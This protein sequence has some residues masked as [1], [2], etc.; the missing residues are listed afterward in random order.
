MAHRVAVYIDGF[1]LYYGMTSKGWSRYLWL[2]LHRLAENLLRPEQELSVVRYFTAPLLA[3]PND[4][5]RVKRQTTYLDALSSR[6]SL[7]I[8]L[9]Y[10]ISKTQNCRNCGAAR[11]VYEEK[12]T[13]VNIAVAML[14]DAYDDI[15]DT[16]VL[17]SAD[18]DLVRPV[19]TVL[20]RF[21]RKRVV[22]AFPPGRYSN[23]LRDKATASFIIG[24]GVVANSQLPD[25]M[26]SQDGHSLS[27][28]SNWT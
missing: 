9:G 13:D 7:S 14:A 23:D 1:N 17:V 4:S 10:Y 3:D 16:A 24:R 21:Q 18:G 26:V 22:V 20:D 8:Q 2:D 15:Y 5:D 12:T 28:P 19:T 6:P 11:T 27:R 25:S